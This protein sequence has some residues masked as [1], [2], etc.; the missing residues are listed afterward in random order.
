MDEVIAKDIENRVKICGYEV[1]ALPEIGSL[2]FLC[3][4]IFSIIL[5]RRLS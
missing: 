3:P 2:L 5:L 4:L 1:I